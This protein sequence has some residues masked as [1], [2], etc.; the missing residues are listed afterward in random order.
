VGAF[1][2][3]QKLGLRVVE[4]GLEPEPARVRRLGLVVPLIGDVYGGISLRVLPVRPD[5][6]LALAELWTVSHLRPDP[7]LVSK[8][9]AI[10]YETPPPALKAA[11]LGRWIQKGDAFPAA[12]DIMYAG[13][14]GGHIGL[15]R[16]LHMD[17]EIVLPL[18]GRLDPAFAPV[19][20]AEV[21]SLLLR[22]GRIERSYFSL[23][24]NHGPIEQLFGYF[25]LLL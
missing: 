17:L 6:R 10:P 8:H 25:F 5:D 9:D 21:L 24:A 19:D 22:E 16:S 4:I 13:E 11:L 23:L 18:R 15:G 20:D 12:I 7:W 3:I 2:S 14:H 1:D